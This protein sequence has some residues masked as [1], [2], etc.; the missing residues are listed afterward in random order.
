[1]NKDNIKNIEF[2]S[3]DIIAKLNLLSNEYS[4]PFD[5]LIN[6]AVLQFIDDVNLLRL[7]RN[8]NLSLDYLSARVLS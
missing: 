4:V 2:T 6:F 3:H 5:T 1:M 7:L 8:G